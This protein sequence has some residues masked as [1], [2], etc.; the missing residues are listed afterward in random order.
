MNKEE[1]CLFLIH[2]IDRRFVNKAFIFGSLAGN[3]PNPNDCDLFI[4]TNLTPYDENWRIFLSNIESIKSEFEKRFSLKLNTTINS[5]KEYTEP[6]S[7]RERV[8]RACF[9]MA[10]N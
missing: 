5:E 2:G 6:S 3:K 9:E 4:V 10:K 1:M 8:L 7:F